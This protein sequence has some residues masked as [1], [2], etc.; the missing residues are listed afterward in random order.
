MLTFPRAAIQ[1]L[2]CSGSLGGLL[3]NVEVISECHKAY[4]HS[5]NS[6]FIE[7]RKGF[8]GGG[9]LK[10]SCSCSNDGKLRH[11]PDTGFHRLY[12]ALLRRDLHCWFVYCTCHHHSLGVGHPQNSGAVC[13]TLHRLLGY[14]SPRGPCITKLSIP[15][16]LRS[17]TTKRNVIESRPLRCTSGNGPILLPPTRKPPQLL[18]GYSHKRI[19][20]R[21]GEEPHL[22]ILPTPPYSE[23]WFYSSIQRD[24]TKSTVWV[25]RRL[26]LRGFLRCFPSSRRCVWLRRALGDY[27]FCDTTAAPD[28]TPTPNLCAPLDSGTAEAV[29]PRP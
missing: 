11:G 2:G 16:V 24:Q 13:A 12:S 19:P 1:A 23:F 9:S 5:V 28:S 18:F 29:R 10:D 3:F 20:R 6:S 7:R 15:I 21:Q 4:G 26:V 27:S 25:Y 22:L 14:A 8:P 17:P